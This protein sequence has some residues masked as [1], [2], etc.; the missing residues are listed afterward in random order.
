MLQAH[1]IALLVLPASLVL[2]STDERRTLPPCSPAHSAPTPPGEVVRL[3]ELHKDRHPENILV[4]HTYADAACRL[5]GSM[6]EKGRLVDMYWRMNAG[7]AAECYKPT[8]PMIKFTTLKTLKVTALSPDKAKL[9]IDITLL[10]RLRHDLPTRE[11]EVAL[12]SAGGSCTAEVV[13]PLGRAERA[14]RLRIQ[15]IS[16]KGKYRMG[17]PHKALD[18]L[19]LK[20]VDAAGK[21]LRVV[22]YGK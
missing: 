16:A 6:K 4:V 18:R 19:A 5:I 21:P 1:W 9:K 10:D 11:A 2:A 13:L 8:H 3:F 17:V 7:T 22:F 15:E 12:A 20:G 14:A